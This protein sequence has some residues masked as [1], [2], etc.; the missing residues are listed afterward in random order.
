MENSG[1]ILRDPPAN[2]PALVWVDPKSITPNM[3][4]WR[5]H[6]DD[7]RVLVGDLINGVGW[8]D[9]CLFNRRTGEF[10]NGHLRR[11]IAIERGLDAIPVLVGDW[12]REEQD[13]IHA[14][15]D[16]STGM[17]KTDVDK[18]MS[19]VKNAG[20][21][22][23]AAGDILRRLAE[24]H[25]CV[26]EDDDADAA[27][28]GG[29]PEGHGED[30]SVNH[31]E[32]IEM[33]RRK[34]GVDPGQVW[35]CRSNDGLRMHRVMCGDCT[36][37]EHV[38]NL[39]SDIYANMVF[40]SPPY[41]NQ[42]EYH[43]IDSDWTRL[44]V[45]FANQL[46]GCVRENAQ[47]IINLGLIHENAEWVPYWTDAFQ[48]MSDIGWRRF[49]WYVWDQTMGLPGDWHGRLAPSFE[50]LFHFNR[51]A[52]DANKC[53]PSKTYGTGEKH[54]FNHYR[55]K[56]RENVNYHKANYQEAGQFKVPDSVVR[57]LRATLGGI[58]HLHPAVFPPDLPRKMI[59][60]Y[61]NDGDIVYDSFGGVLTT[62]LACEAAGRVGF[63]M[64]L[65]PGYVSVGLERLSLAGLAPKRLK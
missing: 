1:L 39:F 28:D 16:L 61:S 24:K 57:V 6:T 31:P 46:A 64:E 56:D 22:T 26:F 30:D 47:I 15:L 18:L 8:A 63:S 12:S 2:A 55:N 60:V 65:S 21:P 49:G 36:D 27:G 9:V 20:A 3:R 7:Q 43:G 58:A 62:V 5:I 40:T 13:A 37:P 52:R 35:T 59:E 4:N 45:G 34:W 50:F 41:G 51:E 38:E 53:E 10:V 14:S 54:Q 23:E 11:D 29:E 33:L 32:Q 25:G 44:I 19:L 17:A 48:Y 42:R